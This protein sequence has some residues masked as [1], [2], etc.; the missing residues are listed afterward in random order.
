MFDASRFATRF[1]RLSSGPGALNSH[2]YNARILHT[3]ES[4]RHIDGRRIVERAVEAAFAPLIA[5]ACPGERRGHLAHEVAQ[6]L[7]AHLGYG[8]YDLTGD[9]AVSTASHFVEGWNAGKPGSRRCVCTFTSAYLAMAHA[10]ATGELVDY[11]ERQCMVD[12]ARACRFERVPGR[13]A[14]LAP[15]GDPPP[16][17][18]PPPAGAGNIDAAAIAEAVAAMPLHGN[19]EGLIPAFNLY[20][21][22]TPVDFYDRLSTDFVNEMSSAGLGRHARQLLG[23]DAETCAMHTFRGIL[24]SPEWAAAVAPMVLIPDDNLFGLIALAS[25][26]GWGSWRVVEHARG[27][28]VRLELAGVASEPR[29]WMLTGVAAALMELL[30]STGSIDE[31]FGTFTATAQGSAFTVEKS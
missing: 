30:Y 9:G 29:R 24:A 21:A 16:P 19:S 8:W 20:L 27:Q 7:Y 11:I 14:P 31:R 6:H 13:T 28:R 15:P 3:V 25:A 12:G 1:G 5:E 10:I 26:F 4:A 23:N 22:R 17:P 2:H 18:E